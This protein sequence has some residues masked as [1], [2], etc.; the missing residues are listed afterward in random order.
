MA[1]ESLACDVTSVISDLYRYLR[2][3][4]GIRLVELDE[5]LS[6]I[7]QR[8]E[9]ADIRIPYVAI[10]LTLSDLGV[11]SPFCLPNVV[12]YLNQRPVTPH[13]S[14][15]NHPSSLSGTPPSSGHHY[16]SC[17]GAGLLGTHSS[18]VP[19]TG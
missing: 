13:P 10:T 4:L 7:W 11:A 8:L 14:D 2:D 17:P 1:S 6:T 15:P 16:L 3:L 19:R 18:L 9:K 12:F 5:F